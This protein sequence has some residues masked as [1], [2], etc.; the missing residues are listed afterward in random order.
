MEMSILFYVNKNKKFALIYGIYL[1]DM[2]ITSWNLEGKAAQLKQ[3]NCFQEHS[4]Q[5]HIQY[6]IHA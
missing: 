6:F 3:H 4:F 2:Q 1:N 5:I